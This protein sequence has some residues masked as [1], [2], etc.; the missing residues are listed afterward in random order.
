MSQC[1]GT[2]DVGIACSERNPPE[3]QNLSVSRRKLNALWIQGKFSGFCKPQKKTPQYERLLSRG[4]YR[5]SFNKP[6]WCALR[7]H[8][9]GGVHPVALTHEP[10]C[11]RRAAPAFTGVNPQFPSQCGASESPNPRI[12]GR[13]VMSNLTSMRAPLVFLG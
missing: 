7:R 13:A 2:R 1:S 5:G 3:F 4:T 9:H 6:A 12:G 8:S 11:P 10:H